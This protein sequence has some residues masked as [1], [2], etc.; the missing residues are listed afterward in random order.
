MRLFDRDRAGV[1]LTEQGRWIAE[2][3]E[4]LLSS[5][6][7]F[8]HQVGF[9]ARG[10]ECRSRFGLSSVPASALLPALMP[11]FMHEVVVDEVEPLW[12]TGHGR[13]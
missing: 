4:A 2:K 1:M 9:V 6:N 7:D 11:A 13:D 3:T 10:A 5:A 12:P 8:E